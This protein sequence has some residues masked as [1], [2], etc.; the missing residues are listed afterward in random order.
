MKTLTNAKTFF[1]KCT[2]FLSYWNCENI[3]KKNMFLI[4][5]LK[6]LEAY[7]EHKDD[8]IEIMLIIAY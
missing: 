8:K 7:K 4:H 2:C 3:K 1:S 6:D 5:A